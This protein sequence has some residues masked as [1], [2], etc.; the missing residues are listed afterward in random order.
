VSVM[1]TSFRT[2]PQAALGQL[3]VRAKELAGVPT[4][5]G[6]TKADNDATMH[7]KRKKADE[8]YHLHLREE[9]DRAE[10]E[11]REM[12]EEVQARRADFLMLTM[13]IS[14][15]RSSPYHHPAMAF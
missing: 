8:K 1:K 14:L 3:I 13:F 10:T 12:D 11:R 4:V 9:W 5:H 15:F 6:C 7:R 2:R